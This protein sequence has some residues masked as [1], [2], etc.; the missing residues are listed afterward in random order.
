[1]HYLEKHI[2]VLPNY[3]KEQQ[4][5]LLAPENSMS[6]RFGQ[7]HQHCLTT[8]GAN[9]LCTKYRIAR[10][11]TKKTQNNLRRR[12]EAQAPYYKPQPFLSPTSF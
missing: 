11:T 10:A 7:A 2:H 9:H 1:M 6:E 4:S 3:M 5:G 12:W 8:L